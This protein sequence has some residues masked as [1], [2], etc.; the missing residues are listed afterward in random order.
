MFSLVCLG[1][2]PGL[3]GSQRNARDPWGC[4]LYH[5]VWGCLRCC[6]DCL[7]RE[8]GMKGETDASAICKHFSSSTQVQCHRSW[9]AQRLPTLVRSSNDDVLPVSFIQNRHGIPGCCQFP[10]PCPAATHGQ[11]S[12][13]AIANP[14]PESCYLPPF[15][16]WYLKQ[17][18][19]H[20]R[21]IV[22]L[23]IAYWSCCV[24]PQPKNP[25]EPP[26]ASPSLATS[27]PFKP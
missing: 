16:H 6:G 5:P 14:P 12:P 7:Q 21:F 23:L 1:I 9:P 11:L 24:L 20:Q 2:R 10:V 18:K 3:I 25:G 15:I 4:T 8:S 22:S 27:F 19:T 13:T 26:P 17:K